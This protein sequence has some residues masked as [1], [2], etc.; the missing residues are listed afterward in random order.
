MKKYIILPLFVLLF[1]SL[2]AQMFYRSSFLWTYDIDF[3]SSRGTLRTDSM[4]KANHVS[5]VIS[6]KAN[7]QNQWITIAKNAYNDL[8]VNYMY[9]YFNKKGLPEHYTI[10]HLIDSNHYDSLLS[11][12]KQDT[13]LSTYEFNAD[14]QITKALFYNKK[15]QLAYSYACQYNTERRLIEVSGY[16]AKGEQSY[17]YKYFYYDNGSKRETHYINKNNKLKKVWTYACEPTG[18]LTSKVSQQNICK[19]RTY[20]ADSSYFEIYEGT[21]NK[22]HTTRRVVKYSKNNLAL[23]TSYFNKNDKEIMKTV[24][25]FNEKG[26][27]LSSQ[28][29]KK[30]K[31][32]YAQHYTYDNRGFIE[33]WKE[34][35]AKGKE[36]SSYRYEYGYY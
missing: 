11:I 20:N 24:R 7:K 23:E 25:T 22:G 13:I 6:K 19:R 12:H 1:C 17:K 21:D 5:F 27:V 34:V 16:N 32:V 36:R 26:K 31:L 29:F 8:G 3:Y 33:S 15:H 4:Y 14:K 10:Y 9:T 18:V 35:T 28:D 30:G 2:K